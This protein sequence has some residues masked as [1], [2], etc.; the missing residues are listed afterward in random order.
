MSNVS[1]VFVNLYQSGKLRAFANVVFKLRADGDGVYTISG[2]KVFEGDDGLWVG[3]PSQ[4][5][6]SGEYTDLIKLQKDREDKTKVT[7]E[8]KEWLEDVSEKVI[9]AYNREVN[10]KVNETSNS[11][12]TQ[13]VNNFPKNNFN[14]DDIPF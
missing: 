7:Q 9:S 12:Q 10:K 3:L 6:N 4:K 14:D 13:P 8:A 2:F 1:H 5:T 11:P